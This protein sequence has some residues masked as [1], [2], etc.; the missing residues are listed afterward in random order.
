MKKKIII[1]IGLLITTSMFTTIEAK[2]TNNELSEIINLYKNG[3]YTECYQKLSEY[4]Q[5]DPSNALAYYYYAISSAQ[6]GNKELAIENYNKVIELSSNNSNLKRYANIGKICLESPEYCGNE[7]A[8]SSKE[9]AFIMEK[10]G[11]N[12]SDEVKEE[13]EKLK[14]EQI[15]RDMNRSK[16]IEPGRFREY[17]DFSKINYQKKNN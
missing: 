15:T 5:N 12:I 1:I 11:S 6:I 17:V 8:Y 3:N 16:E 2:N 7:K 13:I 14:I 10:F 9:E 4:T